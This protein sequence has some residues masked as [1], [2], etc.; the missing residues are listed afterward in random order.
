R[1]SLGSDSG[2]A[3][4]RLENRGGGAG[5]ARIVAGTRMAQVIL[6]APNGNARERSRA[7]YGLWKIA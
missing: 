3:G 6:S 5:R 7:F 2:G 1:T 4:W